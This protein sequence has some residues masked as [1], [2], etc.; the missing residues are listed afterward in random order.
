MKKVYIK[1]DI[2]IERFI[3]DIEIASGFNEEAYKLLRENW[4]ADPSDYN[5]DGMIDEADFQYFL[6]ISGFDNSTSNFCYFSF[7]NVS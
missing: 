1:P 5:G 7:A 3:M 4:E 2:E 6:S